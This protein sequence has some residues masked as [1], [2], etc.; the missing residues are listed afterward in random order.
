MKFISRNLQNVEKLLSL[1]QRFA[2][3]T[4]LA[5]CARCNLIEPFAR[6]KLRFKTLFLK[7]DRLKKNQLTTPCQVEVD[8]SFLVKLES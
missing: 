6:C 7:S 8:I 4:F 5:I 1:L 2:R 3:V